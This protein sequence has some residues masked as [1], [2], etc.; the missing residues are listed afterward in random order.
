MR[1]R[2]TGHKSALN[3]RMTH[4]ATLTGLEVTSA[5]RCRDVL[6]IAMFKRVGV[7]SSDLI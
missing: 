2:R 4:I 1:A 6:C 3:N 7:H 5:E